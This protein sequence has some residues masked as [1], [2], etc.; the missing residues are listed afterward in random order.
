MSDDIEYR[1]PT[2]VLEPVSDFKDW[3]VS[4]KK[5]LDEI[6]LYPVS[7]QKKLWEEIFDR[8]L[9]QK[10][11]LFTELKKRENTRFFEIALTSMNDIYHDDL[12]SDLYS[13][14]SI[15]YKFF[16]TDELICICKNV[17]YDIDHGNEGK[18]TI[19]HMA[20]QR[21][22]FDYAKMLIRNGADVNAKNFLRVT[23][24]DYAKAS[25][26]VKAKE[27]LEWVEDFMEVSFPD[28]K[29]AERN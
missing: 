29:V 8:S 6:Q 13:L 1:I 11:H 4:F 12:L 17:G 10:I 25:S 2:E 26:T 15:Y 23:P 20:I 5:V 18:Y 28:V 3:F 7:E 9:F 14:S 22:D 27:F 24:I 19:L 21:E 16:D